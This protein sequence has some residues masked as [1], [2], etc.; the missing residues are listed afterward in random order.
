M[1]NIDSMDTEKLIEYI[2][3]EVMKRTEVSKKERIERD[4]VLAISFSTEDISYINKDYFHIDH[5][6]E[7]EGNIDITSYKYIFLGSMTNKDI[8]NIAIGLPT[9]RVSSAV[10]D[11]IFQGKRIYVLREGVQYYKYKDTSNVPFYNMMKS[12]ETKLKSFGIDFI[13]K[14]DINNLIDGNQEDKPISKE[15]VKGI[16]E[17]TLDEKIITEAVI[18][19][20]YQKGYK[21]VVINK[22]T[23]ITP[24]AK[25]YIRANRINILSKLK[26]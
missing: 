17:Y 19:D 15:V 16:E 20:I 21:D 3:Q 14:N 8:V 23:K 26:E 22:N 10:I 7:I 2:M 13:S 5:L 1:L 25:D 24:L 12:Y 6:E 9:D 4:K 18:K 11:C